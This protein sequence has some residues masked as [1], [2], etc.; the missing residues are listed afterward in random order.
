MNVVLI[1]CSGFWKSKTTFSNIHFRTR[2][3]FNQTILT[4]KISIFPILPFRVSCPSIGWLVGLH[5]CHN[6]LKGLAVTLPCSYRKTC[7]LVKC[8]LIRLPQKYIHEMVCVFYGTTTGCSLNTALSKVLKY[9]A[10]GRS[11]ITSRK[12]HNI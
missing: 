12:K 2:L 7:F 11:T 1:F 9:I 10:E 8:S 3:F 4:K 5:I 6:F